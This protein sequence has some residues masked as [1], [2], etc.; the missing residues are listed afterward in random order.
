MIINIDSAKNNMKKNSMD[1][2]MDSR[3]G[4]ADNQPQVYKYQLENGLNVLVRPVHTVPSVSMQIWYGVGSKHEKNGERG[5]AHLLE[6]MLFK[7]THKRSESDISVETHKMS[8][9][10]NAFTSYDYTGYLFDLPVQNWRHGFDLFADCMVNATIKEEHLSSEMKAVI[11]ELK[12]NKDRYLRSILGELISIIFQDHPYHHPIIGYKQD[13]WSVKSSDLLSFYKKH[14]KPNNATLVVVGDVDPE[15]VF[16]EAKKAFGS[17]EPDWSHTKEEFYFNQDIIAKSVSI[18]RDVEQPKACF[19]FVVPG[20]SAKKEQFLSL[21]DIILGQGK[22]SRLYKKIVDELQLATA[23]QTGYY[24]LF[25][26]GVFFVIVEPK[27]VEDIETISS[28]IKKELSDLIG[29]GVTDEELEAAIKQSKMALYGLLESNMSQAERIASAFLATGDPEY[30]YNYFDYSVAELKEGVNQLIK[31]Y[32]R[33]TIMHTGLVLPLPA[34]E[35]EQWVA[36]Q[37]ISDEE[38]QRI[39]FGR[40]R[41]TSIEPAVNASKV[42]IGKRVDFLFPKP[43]KAILSNN[44]CVYYYNNPQIPKL[45]LIVSFA[46]RP[47]YDSDT[48][49]GL[50]NFVA[51]MMTEGT[52]K[53]TA[54][55]FAQAIESRGMSISVDAGRITM[56]FLSEDLSFALG[57]LHE[58]LTNVIFDEKEIEKVRHQL[59]AEIKRFWDEPNLICSQLVKEDIYKGHPYSKNLLGTCDSINKITRQDLIAFYN[60]YITLQGAR[61]AVVG[62]LSAYNLVEELEN[63]LGENALDISKGAVVEPI[64]F[65]AIK[66]EKTHEINYPINRDQ[67][68]LFLGTLSVDRKNPDYDKLLLFDQ[69]FGGGVLDSMSSRLFDL[70][71]ETGLFYTIRGSLIS[72]ADEQPGMLTVKTIVSLDRLEEAEKA[73][74]NTMLTT[75]DTITEEEFEQAKL[76]LINSLVNNFTSSARMAE[77]F[78]FLD[79]YQL[80]V[81]FFDKRAAQLEA[82]LLD[83]VKEAAIKILNQNSLLTVR[84]GRVDKK[85]LVEN[86]GDKKE[87]NKESG[88]DLK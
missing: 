84:V 78:L 43:E 29:M 64:Q 16:E 32:L 35:K 62:D 47:Y 23:L 11:Q 71:E 13:L 48:L 50:Y 70:R 4:A 40:V 67:V 7:G 88:S 56:S 1:S 37:K 77:A 28:V 52:K 20:L 44:A 79:K 34:S 9:V 66:Y 21:V 75:V 87:N 3:L 54:Q 5:S 2:R 63:V 22:S 69:I 80:P 60:K 72:G 74:R 82:I 61:L 57:I 31:N 41:T 76:A 65:P 8:A 18:Y 10:T 17:I 14:Y 24:D 42:E 86:A 83:E 85:G 19:T 51:A 46:A 58:L 49:P 59:I 30:V 81:D 36:L 25:D 68:V 53:Y 55:E 6:H 12:M 45:E 73:I 26:H 27:S 38:D 39:L 33:P 15:E